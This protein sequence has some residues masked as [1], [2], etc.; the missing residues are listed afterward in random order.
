MC[1]CA[2]IYMHMYTT[3]TL[4]HPEPLPYICEVDDLLY[5][6][7]EKNSVLN[8]L[9]LCICVCLCTCSLCAGLLEIE[10]S[11]LSLH[12]KHFHLLSHLPAPLIFTLKDHSYTLILFQL[13]NSHIFK[14]LQLKIK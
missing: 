11:F 1:I 10:L 4:K 2:Y 14:T 13:Y 9:L 7:K 5:S 8:C 6:E 3:S 12:N